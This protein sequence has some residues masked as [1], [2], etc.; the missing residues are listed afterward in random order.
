MPFA[1]STDPSWPLQEAEIE[2]K[3][4]GTCV[5]EFVRRARRVTYGLDDCEVAEGYPGFVVFTLH[6]DGRLEAE[7]HACP[8]VR[9]TK[10][11]RHRK[12]TWSS[13]NAVILPDGT[14]YNLA[15]NPNYEAYWGKDHV[16]E[17]SLMSEPVKA[18]WGLRE[19][20]SKPL[21]EMKGIGERDVRIIKLN[22]NHH[23][24]D[25]DQLGVMQVGV[26]RLSGGVIEMETYFTN[27]AQNRANFV[28]QA[29]QDLDAIRVA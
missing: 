23:R 26:C 4:F 25:F 16:F 21:C 27:S 29:Q 3:V 13:L 10:I 24:P 22:A 1:K 6:Y 7:T 20:E 15:H 28:A 2:R 14:V 11:H 8:V 9:F 17:F 12:D 18:F 5:A 19:G